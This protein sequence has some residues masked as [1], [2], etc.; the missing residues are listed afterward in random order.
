MKKTYVVRSEE[1][2]YWCGLGKW[3]KKLRKAQ[4]FTS[5]QFADRVVYRYKEINPTI[6]EV[7]LE[8]VSETLTNAD[9]IRSMSDEELAQAIY[10]GIS[11]DAC[12]YCKENDHH[13]TGHT[14]QGKAD[15]AV[16]LEW[17]QQPAE[18]VQK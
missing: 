9:R 11:S 1:G 17:L 15:A 12:D 16:I 13:C 8:I 2:E 6:V 7:R 18:E 10:Q 3:D 14:C 4:I 5:T